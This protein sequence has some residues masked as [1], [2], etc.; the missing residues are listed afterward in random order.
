MKCVGCPVV[1]R[2]VV[3]ESLSVSLCVVRRVQEVLHGLTRLPM[4]IQAADALLLLVCSA[5]AEFLR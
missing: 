2:R 4:E 5:S 3:S 1:L